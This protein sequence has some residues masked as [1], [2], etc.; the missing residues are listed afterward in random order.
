MNL[1]ALIRMSTMQS[2][3][4]LV[5]YIGAVLFFISD[6]TLFLVRYYRNPDVVFKKH[7][8]VMITYLAGQLLITLGFLMQ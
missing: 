3:G 7:F 4:S 2:P 8:T 1:L 5:T 6:C